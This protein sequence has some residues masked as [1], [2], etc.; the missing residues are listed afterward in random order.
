MGRRL[1]SKGVGKREACILGMFLEF[2]DIFWFMRQL[3]TGLKTSNFN[4]LFLYLMAISMAFDYC[5]KAELYK[6]CMLM[7][8]TVNQIQKLT[9]TPLLHFR[10]AAH[11]ACLLR[12]QTL[13]ASTLVCQAN[14]RSKKKQAD[15]VRA[16]AETAHCQGRGEGGEE[17]KDEE[18]R[19]I[20][21]E[22]GIGN[23]RLLERRAIWT[24]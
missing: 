4:L 19:A 11:S 2:F 3:E 15:R 14:Y 12:R 23:L 6:H 20:C 18:I 1:P 16:T 9:I 8:F 13:Q 24:G 5:S 17:E 21:R 22:V 7:N 10:A